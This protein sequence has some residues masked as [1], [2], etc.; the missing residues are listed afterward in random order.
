[1]GK[2]A[3][4]FAGQ[5]AQHPGMGSDLCRDFGA[6]RRVFEQADAIRPGTSRQCFEGTDEELKDTSNTQP[7]M[8]AVELATAAVLNSEGVHADMAAGFSLGELGALTYAAAMDFGTGFRLVKRRGE[9]M[10]KASSLYPTAM[11]AVLKLTN[12]QVEALC[13]QFK[14]IYP[15]NYNC[16]G[17]VSVSGAAEEMPAFS[18]AVKEAGG[19]AVPLKVAGAFHSPFMKLAEEGFVKEMDRFPFQT[20]HIPVYSNYTAQ[21]YGSNVP[22][23]LGK[24]LCHPVLWEQS[25]RNM[26]AAGADTFLELGPGRTLCTLIGKIDSSVRA[27]PVSTTEELKKALAEVGTC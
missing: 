19:R 12:E 15:V 8:F 16:P 23:L 4:V 9:L 20:P 27:F 25:V 21:P 18:A 14:Q 17:Q 5:G 2:I 26:I 1:M 7:C 11:A 24:Q 22:D 13:A 10:Q 6:A 3:F